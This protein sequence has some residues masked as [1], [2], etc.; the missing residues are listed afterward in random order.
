MI[1][2]FIKFRTQIFFWFR[3]FCMFLG[4]E[5][6]KYFLG[7]QRMRYSLDRVSTLGFFQFY[8]FFYFLWV[9]SVKFFLM[10]FRIQDLVHTIFQYFCLVFTKFRIYKSELRISQELK[11]FLGYILG[12]VGF[13]ISY[14]CGFTIK[15]FGLGFTFYI[16]VFF[17]IL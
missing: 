3:S 7:V 17:W 16:F 12:Y 10:V 14:V 13:M 9:L 5:S 6:V 15:G 1:W 11:M 2:E 8:G 4:F